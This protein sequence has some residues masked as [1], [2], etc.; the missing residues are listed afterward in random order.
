MKHLIL[1]IFLVVGLEATSFE[2]NEC[3][4]DIYYGNGIMTT[5][6]EADR[7]LHYTLKPAIQ[8]EI[9]NDDVEKMNKYHHFDLAY[10]YSAKE[11]FGDTP[12]AMALDLMEAYDQLGNTSWGWWTAQ[13]LISWSIG[14]VNFLV[15]KLQLGDA[16]RSISN[17]KF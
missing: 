15:P 4:S 1:F 10:N 8:N 9:Y 16:Y 17:L 3:Q 12:I 14:R 5:Q 7:A 13:Q 6:A 2:I 11:D